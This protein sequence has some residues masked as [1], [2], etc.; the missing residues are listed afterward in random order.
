MLCTF[1]LF[2]LSSA[3]S[4]FR[5]VLT[6]EMPRRVGDG[7]VPGSSLPAIMSLRGGGDLAPVIVSATAFIGTATGVSM[8]MGTKS[9]TKIL[10][11]GLNEFPHDPYIGMAMIGWAVGKLN[12]VMAGP[13]STKRFAQLNTI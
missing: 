8:Y 13:E 11:L 7:L 12:A 3:S 5:V 1:T 4:A 10:W 2:C 6:P 9:F